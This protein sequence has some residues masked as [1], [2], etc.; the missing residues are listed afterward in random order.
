MALV[1]LPLGVRSRTILHPVQPPPLLAFV[2]PYSQPLKRIAL[3]AVT[4]ICL[5]ASARFV[6]PLVK[7]QQE[8]QLARR[9][10]SEVV[11]SD[12][13]T[14][15][16]LLRQ[17]ASLGNSSLEALVVAAAAERADVA[18]QARQIIEEK[19][20]TWRATFEVDPFFELGKPTRLLA[21][22]LATHIL[23]FGPLGQ[24]WSSSLA[25]E[26]VE[27][28]QALSAEDAAALLAD[29][30]TILDHVPA[31]GP[32][33]RTLN[34]G[35]NVGAL[36]ELPV[37]TGGQPDLGLL[38]VPSEHAI[39]SQLARPATTGEAV[40][41]NPFIE[42]SAEIIPSRP[43]KLAWAPI[44][45]PTA[46]LGNHIKKPVAPGGRQN[47]AHKQ[48]PAT[49]L[50]EELTGALIDVPTPDEMQLVIAAMQNESTR[51]LLKRLAS[52]DFYNA[53]AI[54]LVLRDRGITF[55]ELSL[56]DRLLSSDP[57][58]RLRL[59]S[60]LKVL[61]ARPARR[62]LRELL[63]DESAE[64]RLQALTALATTNDPALLG[65]AREMAV[66]DQDARVSEL[67][68]RIMR[69]AR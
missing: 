51:T 22:T 64:V 68:A 35:Q 23:D 26:L 57:A 65:L 9:L 31:L 59:V 40:A 55:E 58:E 61:P 42:S 66:S 30:S 49:S 53:G 29:C 3:L 19:L 69:E 33:V 43:S 38:D 52:A 6:W 62:W 63:T 18:L 4:T 60:D 47:L 2:M 39:S 24:Q 37:S 16:V 10:V 67:A 28:S 45:S 36:F 17:I 12:S 27:L 14:S 1:V 20:G 46:T 25:L 32:R 50:K 21:N 41:A 13:S 54:R 34:P 56:V 5:L 48:P 8:R 15:R 44:L 11:R 7:A